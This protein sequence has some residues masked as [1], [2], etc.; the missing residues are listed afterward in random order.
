[1]SIQLLRCIA[2]GAA[3]LAL[4][5]AVARAQTFWTGPPI[6]FS[7]AAF[8]DVNLPA[9][10]D[11]ITPT[12]W[13]TRATVQGIYNIHQEAFFTAGVSPANTSR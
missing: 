4:L 7:K 5:P 12:T 9:N 8:A 1:M 10:Q 3:V 6:T 11:R 2:F 13:I